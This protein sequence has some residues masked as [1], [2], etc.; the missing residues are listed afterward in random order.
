MP[1]ALS[2]LVA[3][4]SCVVCLPS[5]PNGHSR[6]TFLAHLTTDRSGSFSRMTRNRSEI[7]LSASAT[8]A[9]DPS[10]CRVQ[11]RISLVCRNEIPFCG[12]PRC[13]LDRCRPQPS[14]PRHKMD[15]DGKG[16]IVDGKPT[17]TRRVDFTCSE[18]AK[19]RLLLIANTLYQ[20]FRLNLEFDNFFDIYFRMMY[21]CE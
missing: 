5:F 2:P 12:P 8:T 17:T 13:E 7:P 18:D 9:H 6:D 15:R 16:G 11:T 3:K 20:N 10:G 14:L 19:M 1:G 4:Q 21:A